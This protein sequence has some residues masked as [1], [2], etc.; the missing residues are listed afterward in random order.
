MKTTITLACA[1]ALTLASVPALAGSIALTDSQL[2]AVSGK[3]NSSTVGGS[4][5]TSVLGITSTKGNVQVGYFQ[6]DDT[7]AGD[8]SLN[9]AGN[10][11]SG[12]NSMVQQNATAVVNILAW[13]GASQA[14]TN[15]TASI[16]SS[17]GV[18]SW[19]IM[20]LGGF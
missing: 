10:I 1:T 18:E 3:A 14:V 4:D 15:N 19:W 16:G 7:H 13:G 2:D 11:Q 12:N 8:T 9:K 5:T 17:Q 20:Y 6:W